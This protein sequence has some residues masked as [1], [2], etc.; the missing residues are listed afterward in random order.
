MR[1][2]KS[3]VNLIRTHGMLPPLFSQSVSYH[4]QSCKISTCQYANRLD[5][6]AIPEATSVVI[7]LTCSDP[8]VYSYLYINQC[9]YSACFDLFTHYFSIPR[10]PSLSSIGLN[11]DADI[12]IPHNYPISLKGSVEL[13]SSRGIF[14]TIQFLE[15][16]GYLGVSSQTPNAKGVALFFAKPKTS[17]ELEDS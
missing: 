15:L 8:C 10:I 12:R 14:Q 17:R 1:G 16:T 5:L 4:S 13:I 9:P 6:L 3:L 2:R 11:R 7:T